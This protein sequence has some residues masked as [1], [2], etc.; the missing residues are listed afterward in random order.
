MAADPTPT[1]RI[2]PT[3]A[4]G[5]AVAS[6]ACAFIGSH[7]FAT[8]AANPTLV[9][10]ATI[11]AAIIIPGWLAV[12]GVFAAVAP[13]GTWPSTRARALTLL[14]CLILTLFGLVAIALLLYLASPTV[15]YA[16]A[17]ACVF[18]V[19]FLDRALSARGN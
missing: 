6:L 8:D 17:G 14:A 9:R 19:V 4:F 12:G 2:D 1:S 16:F 11:L 10:I 13:D 18:A 7:L 5:A 15:G 3:W